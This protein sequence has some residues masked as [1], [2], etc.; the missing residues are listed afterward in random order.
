MSTVCLYFVR[1]LLGPD[2]RMNSFRSTIG[3][4]VRPSRLPTANARSP[5]RMTSLP[6]QA[7]TYECRDRGSGP[8]DVSVA[9]RFGLR[10]KTGM[11]DLFWLTD[12]QMERLRPFFLKSHGKPR[13]GDR[14]M[15]NGIMFVNKNALRW[16]DALS[17]YGPHMSTPP[18][19][20]RRTQARQ[21]ASGWPCK[22]C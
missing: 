17:A 21:L 22:G 18:R 2:G 11:S 3:R 20:T 13:V 4:S 9:I 8:I 10:E 14:Q 12:E 7:F 15:L 16:R 19:V 6:P 1:S 5:S